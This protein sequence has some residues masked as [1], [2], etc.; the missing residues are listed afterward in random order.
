MPV[1][2]L[3]FVPSIVG[4]YRV[5]RGIVNIKTFPVSLP[6]KEASLLLLCEGATHGP[7]R[8]GMRHSVN[9]TNLRQMERSLAFLDRGEKLFLHDLNSRVVWKL[10]VIHTRHDAR[11]VVVRRIRVLTRFANHS[12]HGCQRFES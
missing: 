11:K 6:R 12:K 4:W 8:W 5:I 1:L 7:Q 2:F 10:Q 9:Q 3:H